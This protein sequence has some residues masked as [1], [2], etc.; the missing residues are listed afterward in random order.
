MERDNSY[1]GPFPVLELAGTEFYIN[2]Y[3]LAL[4]QVGQ[5]ENR[6]DMMEMLVLDDHVELWYDAETKKAYDGPADQ[7][8]GTVQLYW[9]YPLAAMDPLGKTAW[10]DENRPGWKTDYVTDL[11]VISIAG[12]D[13]FVDDRRNSFRDTKNNWNM[14]AFKDVTQVDQKTGIYI[15]KRVTQVPFPHEFD[16]Y[17]PPDTLPGHI[18]FAE[19]PDGR[20]LAQLLREHQSQKESPDN[21][22]ILH[23][24][25]GR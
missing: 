7:M 24:R 12:K 13:F 10:L 5:P 16:S 20:Q 3:E 21:V 23:D 1:K 6:I 19:V 4:I 25:I 17:N 9:L 22:P 18:V 15:D 2:G 11:P 14:I 8:P